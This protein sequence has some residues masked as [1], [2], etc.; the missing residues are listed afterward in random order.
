MAS[1]EFLSSQH[2][3]LLM[4]AGKRLPQGFLRVC[5]SSEAGLTG[6]PGA[7]C[8]SP[9]LCIPCTWE[10]SSTPS[11]HQGPDVERHVLWQAGKHTFPVVDPQ[12]K[13]Q[14]PGVICSSQARPS[15][16]SAPERSSGPVLCHEV[17]KHTPEAGV[18]PSDH[19]SSARSW[20]ESLNF[21]R[22]SVQHS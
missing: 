11:G 9:R 10:L 5:A 22:P 14:G 13:P 20:S 12:D 8:V 19:S 18:G 1:G 17:H 16:Q 3:G 2:L 6:R 15:L 4:E 21:I 7:A